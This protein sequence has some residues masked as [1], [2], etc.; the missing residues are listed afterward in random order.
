MVNL[1]DFINWRLD[2]GLREA[3]VTHRLRHGIGH[4]EDEDGRI[5]IVLPEGVPAE[6]LVAGDPKPAA[7]GKGAKAG[8]GVAKLAKDQATA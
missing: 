7:K 8:K 2:T 1:R 4:A 3:Q 6:A 5:H